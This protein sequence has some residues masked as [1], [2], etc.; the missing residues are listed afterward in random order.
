MNEIYQNE[1]A[2]SKIYTLLKCKCDGLSD[3][4][5]SSVIKLVNEVV[6]E[7]CE[8][9]KTIIKY[10][11]EYTLHDAT[12]LFRVLSIMER[13]I[14]IDTLNSLS[15]PELMMLI[16]VSFLHDIGMAPEEEKIRSWKKIWTNQE[17]SEKELDE[18]NHFNRFRNTF[19]YKIIE[20]DKLRSNDEHQK[21]NLIEDYIISE[22]IRNTHAARAREIIAARWADKIVYEDK[23]LTYELTQL[24]F[25]HGNDAL[26]LL[27][28]ETNVL[29]AENS[30]LCMPFIGVI[31]RLADLLDF[32]A[33]RTPTI[34]FSHLSVRN[35]VSLKEWQKHRS[36]KAWVIKPEKIAYTAQ[37][38]HPAIEKS[39]NVFCDLIDKELSNCS[40]VLSRI[41]DDFRD[42]V[43]IYKITLPAKVDRRKIQP[44]IDIKTNEP[45]YIYK[46]TSFELSKEQII[47]LLMGTKLYSDTKSALRELIQN[48]I[49]ACLVAQA[50]CN[51]FGIPYFPEII[52][53]YYSEGTTD[54]LEVE[55]NGIGMNQSIIEKYYAKVGSSYYKSK[56]FYDLKAQTGLTFQPISRFGIGILSCFMVSDT[57]EVETRKLLDNGDKDSSFEITIEG[58]DSIFTLKTGKRVAHGTKTRLFL[59]K[60]ENPWE[61]IRSEKF[62]E[63]VKESI[64]N[65]PVLLKVEV[66]KNETNPTIID[67]ASFSLI[68]PNTLKNFQWK[69]EDYIREVEIVFDDIEKGI[70][71]SAIIA[72]LEESGQPV[73][74]IDNLQ[75]TVRIDDEDYTLE[76]KIVLQENE[77]EKI[78]T[79]IEVDLDSGIDTRD[80]KDSLVKSKSKFSIHGIDFPEGIFPDFS[81]RSK[82][83][84]LRWHLPMLLVLDIAGK[85]D[86]DLNSAR[87]EIVYNEKWNKF[88]SEL[89][90]IIIEKLKEQ[91]DETYWVKL[92]D[93]LI[94][95]KSSELFIESVEQC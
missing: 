69:S 5:G 22:Y 32:D 70:K 62:V 39:I 42:D 18:F 45:R 41:S 78:S 31:I 11:P 90:K 10:M 8:L 37:C 47:D 1:L 94:R 35:P 92:K 86:I 6:S 26:S 43:S 79:V 17:P 12:H 23:N 48:S 87:T 83:A 80:S 95:S 89:S 61:E 85:N 72:L 30:Y 44:E 73:N 77:I 60:K 9:S 66:D 74:L 50:L 16:L 46:D 28:L 64:P 51:K 24:C 15:I 2:Q 68:S 13:L 21:A 65:P 82:K 36:I 29:C 54:I 56:E 27:D 93:V 34:L 25:S 91:L 84:K 63:Y 81:S 52:V 53:R 3:G 14:P 33:K 76:N 57:I 58:Y 59:R 67:Q 4:I 71:G 38:S 49:D 19:P 88:E 75:R 7:S 40:N 20:I 55:D